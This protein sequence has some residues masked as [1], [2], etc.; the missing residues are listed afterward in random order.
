MFEII[1]FGLVVLCATVI[2]LCRY[3]FKAVPAGGTEKIYIAKHDIEPWYLDYARSFFPVLLIV[4]LLRGFV[5]EP[6]RI[7]SGSMLPTLKVGDFILVNKFKYGIRLPILHDKVFA[8]DEPQ[9]G[10][11]MVFRYP[12][13]NKTHYI[14]RVIGLPGDVIEYRQKRLSINGQNIPIT[15]DGSY[16]P[17]SS[18]GH[19]RTVNRYLQALPGEEQ[20]ADSSSSEFS[21]LLNNRM[22]SR[23][24]R[25]TVPEG[26]YFMMGDNRD[27]SQDSRV[28]GFVPEQNI[29]G[30]AFF[31][32]F[33]WNSQAGGGIDLSRIGEEI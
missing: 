29:V 25:W 14:K 12:R 33:H 11:I 28:W 24:H 7:P 27:N 26:H 18:N 31:I 3:V 21:I 2:M 5:A 1:L 6:F 13:D 23:S 32:W 20:S 16:V 15:P 19:V 9:R 10:E 22:H 8:M 30:E 4:F 17:F